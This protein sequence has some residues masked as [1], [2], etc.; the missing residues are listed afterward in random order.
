MIYEIPCKDSEKVYVGET[1]RTSKKRLY[2]R[3]QA[4]MKFDMNNGVAA[5]VHKE[6]HQIDWEDTK[7]VGQEEFYWKRR[8]MEAIQIQ[9]C[10]QMCMNLDCRLSLSGLWHNLLL[11]RPQLYFDFNFHFLHLT[12]PTSIYLNT[13]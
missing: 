13:I 2:E 3:K 8:V 6:D 10:G 1:F 4:V 5:R 7:V 11:P 12:P 9:Q